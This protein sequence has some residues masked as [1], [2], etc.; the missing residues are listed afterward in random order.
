MKNQTILLRVAYWTGA[1]LDGIMVFPLLFPKVAGIMFKI[2]DFNPGVDTRYVMYVGAS[3]MLGW[4]I[5]LIWADRKPIERR[6]VILITAC[7]V[8]IGLII[9]NIYG[10]SCGFI[11]LENILPT[12]ILQALILSLFVFGYAFSA[13][14]KLRDKN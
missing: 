1:V 12:L 10:V 6:D 9:A 8:V 7:P 5:L 11:R 3:L 14:G 2:T 13:K 4:T